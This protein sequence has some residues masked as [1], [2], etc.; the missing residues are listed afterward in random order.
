MRQIRAIAVTRGRPMT[1]TRTDWGRNT[2][3]A[4]TRTLDGSYRYK[5]GAAG[6]TGNDS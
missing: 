2:P 1:L 6:D 5:E 4:R 3:S